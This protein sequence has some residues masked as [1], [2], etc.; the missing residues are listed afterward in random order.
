MLGM[1]PPI[2]R[3]PDFPFC[4]VIAARWSMDRGD[5]SVSMENAEQSVLESNGDFN[6]LYQSTPISHVSLSVRSIALFVNARSTRI[7][8]DPSRASKNSNNAYRGCRYP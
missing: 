7:T 4:I 5:A 2:P 3:I 6:I 8:G 1:S